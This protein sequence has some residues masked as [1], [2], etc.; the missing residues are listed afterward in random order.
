MNDPSRIH[1][2]IRRHLRTRL[3]LF[4][5]IVML[6]P[7]LS[8]PLL[9]LRSLYL[10]E[11]ERE[12]QD[13][14]SKATLHGRFIEGTFP[15]QSAELLYISQIPEIRRFINQPED[16]QRRDELKARFESLLQDHSHEFR[17]LTLLNNSGQVQ[18][19]AS[20]QGDELP[21]KDDY[22]SHPTFWG[23]MHLSA[24]EGQRLPVHLYFDEEENRLLFSSLV[25]DDEGLIQGVL[26]L[27]LDLK[28]LYDEIRSGGP[29]EFC[30]LLN[31]DGQIIL[32]S[33]PDDVCIHLSPAPAFMMSEP[34]GHFLRGSPLPKTLH[35]F[36]RIQPAGQSE[37]R[38]TLVHHVSLK[39]LHLRY[40][41]ALLKVAGVAVGAFIISLLLALR[42]SR[43]VSQPI[44]QLATAADDLCRGYWDSI[45]P[46][47]SSEDEL[48]DLTYSFASMSRQLRQAHESLMDKVQEIG[49]SEERLAQEKEWLSV[50]LRSLS[51]A[52]VATD[53]EG[54][55]LFLNPSA[56]Q[57]IQGAVGKPMLGEVSLLH[58]HNGQP[59]RGTLPPETE[60]PEQSEF[61]LRSKE[62][63]S[64][65]LQIARR[66]IHSQEQGPLGYVF[67]LRNIT[68]ERLAIRERQHSDKLESLAT[69]ANG[70]AH[71]FNNLVGVIM[72]NMSLLAAGHSHEDEEQRLIESSVRATHRARNITHQ[73]MTFAQGGTPSK[74][75]IALEDVIQE[76]LDFALPGSLIQPDLLMPNDLWPVEVDADQMH[77]V[78][79][80]LALNAVD[81]MPQGGRLH[82]QLQNLHLEEALG[83]IPPGNYIMAQV[84]DQGHGIPKEDLERVFDP[85]FSTKS[86]GQGLGLSN[87]MSIIK[88]HDGFVQLR[89][90]EYGT[91]FE[92]YIPANPLATP[93]KKAPKVKSNPKPLR[94]RRILILDD[95]PAILD[96][97]GHLVAY[98]GHKVHVAHG[99]EEALEIQAGLLAEGKALELLIID[100]TLPGQ[101]D[102]TIVLKQLRKA[103]PEVPAL[104]SSGYSE[105][106]RMRDYSQ[107]GF[108]NRLAKPYS[109]E[110]LR[111]VLDQCFPDE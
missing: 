69:L 98:L 53:P 34:V 40:R 9:S 93:Q 28:S 21:S 102:G 94:S 52:V 15:R 13:H 92:L 109:L 106:P 39:N 86:N 95:D 103:Q 67:V 60:R 73:L 44:K 6:I 48:A 42:F 107:Y 66:T 26:V 16:P 85:Y 96:T 65:E 17:Y 105:D 2:P 89:S 110:E 22:H 47:T 43:Q 4:F 58:L 82:L 41:D 14:R 45:L 81:A 38:W 11:L 80:N 59:F 49:K 7:T 23:A 63:D 3:I 51:D 29:G 90:D 31:G 97:S 10:N 5:M 27:G 78:F 55:I 100:L 54:N 25:L 50:T 91:T 19:Q 8:I 76:S 61:L 18:L 24:I 77:Q 57:M 56:A 111:D 1:P 72:G 35:V 101:D 83:S 79:H 62:G 88:A 87:V 30:S 20:R 37:I 68:Q 71:D 64:I 104:I 12:I 74:H 84:Q 33:N 36:T 99:C 108:Q 46:D 75:V 32:P 70:I